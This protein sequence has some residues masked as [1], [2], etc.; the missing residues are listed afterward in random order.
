MKEHEVTFA[1]KID[2]YVKLSEDMNKSCDETLELKKELAKAYV[3][4]DKY[5]ELKDENVKEVN[6]LKL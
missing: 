4:E 2:S 6:E 3:Y 5:K 1:N